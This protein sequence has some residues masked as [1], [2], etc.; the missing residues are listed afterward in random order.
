MRAITGAIVSSKPCSLAKAACVLERFS[1]SAA[2][3]LPS[4]DCA[5]YFRVAAAAAS[6]HNLFRRGLRARHQ[7]GDANL[8]A[9]GHVGPEE[10]D[11]RH[12]DRK[13]KGDM[14]FHAGGD[15][16]VEAEVEVS[17]ETKSKKKKE[18]LQVER[19]VA[20]ADSHIP[21]SPE[22]SS[23]KRMKKTEK[24]PNQET[25]VAVKQ[26]PVLDVEEDLG[27]EKKRNNK[28]ENGHVKLEEDAHEV[29]GKHVND[30]VAERAVASGKKMKRKNNEKEEGVAKDV[31]EEEKP[32]SH[33]D[34]DIV[35]KRKKK[36]GRGDHDDNALE[37]VEHTKKKQRKQS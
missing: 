11:T 9:H 34:L 6:Q 19:A 15:S 2:A 32:V 36:R 37:Q 12:Q 28:K 30:G 1:D 26:E 18:D 21:R 23:E 8:D 31:K 5:T 33:G 20:G 3:H 4:S 10:G 13:R 17:G 35:K 27:R 24:H 16:A 25:I 14:T 7:Q 22:I 29:A